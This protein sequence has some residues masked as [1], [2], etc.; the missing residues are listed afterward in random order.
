MKKGKE[1][2]GKKD[3]LLGQRGVSVARRGLFIQGLHLE[4]CCLL[5]RNPSQNKRHEISF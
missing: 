2:D 3:A 4:M 1:R 5:S